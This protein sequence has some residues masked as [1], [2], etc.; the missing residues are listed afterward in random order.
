M[1]K[2]FIVLGFLFVIV[3]APATFAAGAAFA[4]SPV[5]ATFGVLSADKEVLAAAGCCKERK[6]EGKPWRKGRRDFDSCKE[7]NDR[8]DKDNVFK[9][10]KNYWWDVA[11]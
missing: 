6:S 1:K 2:S 8:Q 9:P 5:P 3:T 10:S 11:C 4:S 7:I